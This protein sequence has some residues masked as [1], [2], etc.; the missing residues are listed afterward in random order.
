MKQLQM[1]SVMTILIMLLS[2]YRIKEEVPPLPVTPQYS[3]ETPQTP[4]AETPGGQTPAPRVLQEDKSYIFVQRDTNAT[5]DGVV[6]LIERMETEG[7][8]FYRTPEH[9][10]GL[11]GPDDVVLLKINAQWAER[12]GTNTDLIRAVA[13]AVAAHPE[14]FTGEI[15]I[16]DNGQG[17]YGTYGTGGSFDWEKTN[18]ADRTQSVTDVI[19]SLQGRM[20]ISGY[21]WDSIT[22]N[23]VGEYDQGDG[24]DGFVIED[25]VHPTGLEISYPKFTTQYGTTISFKKGVWNQTA[26]A[27]DSDRL[28]VIN[29]PVLKRHNIYRMTGAVKAYMGIVANRLTGHR[30]HNSVGNGGMGTLMAETRMPTLNIMDMVWIGTGGGPGTGYSAASQANMLAASTDPAALDYWAAQHVLLPETADSGLDPQDVAPGGFG[31]WL[32]L[33][34]L[35]MQKAGFAA[36]VSEE[37]MVLVDSA[38]Q[39]ESLP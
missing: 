17:Q 35:E 38:R 31:H 10:K 29:L 8:Y 13:E 34:A 28:K 18:S 15:I 32:R 39:P 14:G 30:P 3:L 11:I 19:A 22:M 6:R 21:L 1:L 24:A 9:A 27:Y 20:K 33:S 26:T 5:D 4:P 23:R 12:G 36:A 37:Q 2:S 7:Q 25:K 16:A